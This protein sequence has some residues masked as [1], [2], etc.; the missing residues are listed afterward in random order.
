MEVAVFDPVRAAWGLRR[1]LAFGLY[2]VV[3]ADWLVETEDGLI[4]MQPPDRSGAAHVSIF[5]RR[6]S[7][8]TPGEASRLLERIPVWSVAVEKDGPHERSG[9]GA[10]IATA[11]CTETPEGRYWVIGVR[12]TPTRAVVFTYND[13]GNATPHR[14]QAREIFESLEPPER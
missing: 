4:Q 12:V 8:P 3:P 9:S 2:G 7:S 13:D 11:S 6:E 14:A 10:L 1:H 5:N